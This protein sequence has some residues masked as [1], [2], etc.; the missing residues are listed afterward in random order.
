MMDA[1]RSD[2]MNN[3]V[4]TVDQRISGV[5]SD[6]SNDIEFKSTN[7]IADNP[8]TDNRLILPPEELARRDRVTRLKLFLKK[9]S[10]D[11]CKICAQRDVPGSVELLPY[12]QE[13]RL[14]NSVKS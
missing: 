6:R 5:G 2:I 4:S 14:M 8:F 12:L 9:R 11:R 13:C 1:E 10:Q 7:F 3:S